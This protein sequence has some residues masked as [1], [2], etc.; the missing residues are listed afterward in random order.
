VEHDLPLA[1]DPAARAGLP[2]GAAKRAAVRAMF[3]RIAPRYDVLNRLFTAGLDQRWRRRALAAAHVGPADVVVDLACGTGDLAALAVQRGAR[4]VGVD[5]ALG[6]LRGARRRGVAAG[7]AQ[8]DALALPFRDGSVQAVVCGFALR[9]FEAL[10]PAFREMARVL[11]PGGRVALL[12]VDRPASRLVRTGHSF[13]FD[14]VVPF[15]GGLVSDRAAYAY[16]PRSTAYLP[17]APTLLATLA[18]AG[19]E[20]VRRETLLLGT[21]QLVTGTRAGRRSAA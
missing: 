13:Y 15:I 2:E 12:D 10:P 7:F 11:V 8:G 3:D 21:A 19:F 5:M 16:L 1:A 20:D 6:M 4:V 9:N 18:A 17:P 14:R